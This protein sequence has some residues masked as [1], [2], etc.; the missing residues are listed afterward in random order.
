MLVNS[1]NASN[2]EE[3]AFL[4]A[5]LAYEYPYQSAWWISHYYYFN[6][7]DLNGLSRSTS[8]KQEHN[9]KNKFALS[10]L[11]KVKKMDEHNDKIGDLS[12]YEI[13]LNTIEFVLLVYNLATIPWAKP[14]YY[15]VTPDIRNFDFEN[16]PVIIPINK[17]LNPRLPEG[18]EFDKNFSVYN[19]EPVFIKSVAL[20]CRVMSSMARPKVITVIGSDG[21]TY[22]LLLKYESGWEDLTKESRFIDYANFVN[23][24]LNNNPDTKKKNLQLKTYSITP[25]TKKSGIIEWIDDTATIKSIVES[26]SREKNNFVD[27]TTLVNDYGK[28]TDKKIENVVI[29]KWDIIYKRSGSVLWSYFEDR[30]CNA[31]FN[32]D[33]RVNFINSYSLWCIVG[34][35]IGLG[36]RH[37][38]NIMIHTKTGECSHVDF[39]WIFEKGK[40]LPVKEIVPFRLT[41]NI[42]DV[43]GTLK[44]ECLFLK[45]W[46]IVLKAISQNRESIMGFFSMFT[47]DPVP[48]RLGKNIVKPEQVLQTIQD[49]MLV[50]DESDKAKI[51]GESYAIK[52]NSL[53]QKAMLHDNLKY[54]Y[55]G[56]APWM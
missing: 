8:E 7:Y 44:E 54:M 48:I 40:Y 34:Y 17:N 18:D 26:K 24:I 21:Q 52:V 36:D 47:K 55:Y 31:N 3:I 32:L 5:K 23:K 56:W 33:A 9:N 11:E 45:T 50:N 22:K 4:L 15:T 43:F 12:S 37:L 10:I 42:L 27:F 51:I 41:K 13:I 46:E 28:G 14:G 39:E 6:P 38:D 49:K 16:K 25:I 29:D 53:A 20:E 30:F 2:T 1:K 19:E 35:I